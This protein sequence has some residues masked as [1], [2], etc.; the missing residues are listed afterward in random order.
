MTI[1]QIECFCALAKFNNFTR[2]AESMYLSQPAFS[3]AVQALE[4]ELGLTLYVRD[5]SQ[6][7]LTETGEKMLPHMESMLSEYKQVCRISQTCSDQEDRYDGTII[8]GVYRFGLLDF[9]PA[10]IAEYKKLH[11]RVHFDMS[12]HTG[13]S[14]FPALKSCDVDLTHTSY[15]PYGFRKYMSTLEIGRHTHKAML[16]LNHPLASCSSISLAELASERF[17]ALDRRQFPLMNS[18]LVEACANAGFSPNIVREFD[19]FT[20]L[21]DYVSEG[22]A[23]A[24]LAMPA[25]KHPGVAAVP[26]KGLKP[27]PT[28]LVWATANDKPELQDF[29]KYIKSGMVENG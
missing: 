15:I 19:T 18:R 12:E 23:I 16:P 1:H 13:V 9:L 20:N 10:K 4:E 27:D 14:I 2:A 17:V 22:K 3:R 29:I 21:F 6:P 7:R 24:V 8:L 28:Y 5:K 11:P 25:P 26:V